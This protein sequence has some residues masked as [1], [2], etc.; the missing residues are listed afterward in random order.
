M[1]A[2]A[3]VFH[4]D[5]LRIP[6]SLEFEAFRAWSRSDDFPAR[7]RI[8]Y[9]GGEVDIDMSP[10]EYW[11]H[12]ALKVAVAARLHQI[13]VK[14]RRDGVVLSDRARISSPAAGVSAEPDVLVL[15]QETVRSGRVRLVPKAGTSDGRCIE[16]EGPI[17]L[18]VE[19]L[20][21][22]SVRKDTRVLRDLYA[23]AGVPE[24]W[25]ADGRAMPCRLTIL[26]LSG[27]EFEESPRDAD[28]FAV[29]PLLGR[30]LRLVRT[31]P[32]LEFATYDIEERP[33]SSD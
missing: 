11:T 8:D 25:I 28:G 33:A 20:S 4:P 5:E 3:I 15:L 19:C 6:A 32:E 18:V 22:S 26:R 7:G 2:S 23:R 21:D 17:D 13:F 29:S 14:E 30:A 27:G 1:T 24:Y 31:S 9:L 12:G 10:D 16:A